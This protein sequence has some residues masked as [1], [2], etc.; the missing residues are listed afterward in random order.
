MSQQFKNYLKE[1]DIHQVFSSNYYT[2]SNGQIEHL[3]RV[4]KEHLLV[5]RL[6]GKDPAKSI[7]DFLILYRVTPHA[8]TGL[9]PAFLLHGRQPHSKIDISNLRIRSQVSGLQADLHQVRNRVSAKQQQS[10][11]YFDQR[12]GA[13]KHRIK[14]G[15]LVK[16][17]LHR[18]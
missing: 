3:N 15:D 12:K 9:S 16:I 7:T 2:Q 5:A 4:L 11:E 14:V 18:K 13:Q 8:V 10:K 17:R 6:E 1:K